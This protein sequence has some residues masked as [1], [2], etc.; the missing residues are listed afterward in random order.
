MTPGRLPM[1]NCP[2][3]RE[4]LA[5]D[6][7]R[8]LA[9]ASGHRFDLAREGY[10]NLLPANRKRSRAPGDSVE[11]IAARGRIHDAELY[12]P[13]ATALVE[14][15]RASTTGIET[16][17]DLGCGEAY[18]SQALLQAFPGLRLYG[19]DISKSAVRLAARRCRAGHFAVASAFDVPLPDA[20][21]DLVVSVFAPT[22]DT[23]L[24]RLLDPGGLYLKVV[25]APQHLWELRCLLYDEPR[26]HPQ[27]QGCPPGFELLEQRLL[28]YPLTVDAGL[29]GD[30]VAMTPY[31]HRG[32][33]AQRERLEKLEVLSLQM[34][35]SLGVMRRLLP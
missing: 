8:S 20:S 30:L 31:A 33:R 1:W 12:R 9:C 22:D 32:G 4:M 26:P 21:L 19:I 6:K 2:H 35:F 10:V 24:Q 16:A 23:E 27:E 29:L 15:L 14:E 18:Y 5:P 28:E 3:C 17:L 25:P 13:L 11:M 7:G 34:A